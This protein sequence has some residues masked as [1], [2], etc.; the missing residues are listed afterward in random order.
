MI[1]YFIP[2]PFIFQ[3]SIQK[4][5]F[6]QQ[7]Q[8]S[9]NCTLV[10]CLLYSYFLEANYSNT[11][12]LSLGSYCKRSDERLKK[13]IFAII[14]YLMDISLSVIPPWMAHWKIQSPSPLDR[15]LFYSFWD[16]PHPMRGE[17]PMMRGVVT[18][19]LWRKALKSDEMQISW[20]YSSLS[21]SLSWPCLPFPLAHRIIFHPN[22]LRP[23]HQCGI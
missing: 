3:K 5:D 22:T 17:Y 1:L 18:F 21:P 6:T 14:T 2:Q 10:S 12:F 8:P 11:T 7:R 4:I 9:L 13:S 20:E 16:L 15:G 23:W 19:W